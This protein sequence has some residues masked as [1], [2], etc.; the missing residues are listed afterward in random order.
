MSGSKDLLNSY[1]S[2]A[3]RQEMLAAYFF[4]RFPIL[5]FAPRRE[6]KADGLPLVVSTRM[7]AAALPVDSPRIPI[8]L[9]QHMRHMG[10]TDVKIGNAIQR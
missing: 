6:T 9:L 3:D 4:E 10:L 5:L 2:S 1:R 8:W 7:Y